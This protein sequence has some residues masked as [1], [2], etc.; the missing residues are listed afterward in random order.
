MATGINNASLAERQ[1]V[2]FLLGE[3]EFGADII[4]V[5]EII[6]APNITKVPNAPGYVEGACNL[7]GSVLPVINGRIRFNLDRKEKDE[8]SRVLVIDVDGKATGMVVDRVSEVMRVS[9]ADIE[10]PP[11]IVK[12]V[13]SDYLKGVVK[14]ENGNRLVML[15][16][17]AKALCV[18]GTEKGRT[19]SRDESLCKNGAM[20]SS[21]DAGAADEE[22]L[23]S[24][25]LDKEEYAIGIMNVKEIIRTPQ[26]VK[27]P[28]C[29]AYIEGVISIRSNL[30]PIINLRTYFGMEHLDIN[31]HTRIL[32]VDMGGFTAGIMVDRVSEVLSVPSGVIQPP[33]K[34]SDQSGEQLKG[35]AK[36]N[37][38]KRII[39]LLEPS[40]LVPADEIESIRKTGG[41]YGQEAE[42]ED[43]ER[44]L[45]DEEQLVTFRIDSEE[46][47]VK[48]AS[49]QEINR[50]TAVTKIPRSPYFIQGVVNLRGNVI[51][52]L[53]LRKLFKLPEKQAT[54]ATRII[55]V[56]FNG[57]RTG[58]VVDSV[59]E[60][61]RFEKALVE[62]PPDILSSGIDSDYVEGVAKL[63]GGRRMVLILDTGKVLGFH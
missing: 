5:K 58:I 62:P 28:N 1:L 49:V 34:F 33:P 12:N 10:E 60:V 30:L 55:I 35:L 40:R 48:I 42:K 11:Q 25:L 7:R 23:V 4:D 44:Q 61:L 43:A 57:K 47:G 56:D 32:V 53:D 8:N 3:D 41:A 9:A 26:I 16:D 2:T 18:G 6:R 52:V 21:A 15:L 51:P 46:Y 14:L 17:V 45:L 37:K 59:S 13:D 20:I 29:A 38:G 19:N 22:Q 63:D 24:F 39:L 36:L 27:V 50:M 54:D 31:D